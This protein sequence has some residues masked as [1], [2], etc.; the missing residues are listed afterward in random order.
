MKVGDLVKIK[1]K[2]K[3]HTG[4]VLDL[5][6]EKDP[7]GEAQIFWDDGSIMW[8]KISLKRAPLEVVSQ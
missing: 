5:Y 4:V 6:D 1:S 2:G 7:D 3:T 8:E